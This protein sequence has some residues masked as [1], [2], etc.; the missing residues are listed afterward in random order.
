MNDEN[1]NPGTEIDADESTLDGAVDQVDQ[2]DDAQDDELDL[3]EESGDESTQD[4]SND[5]GSSE[6]D[7]KAAAALA[8]MSGGTDQ[9]DPFARFN[10]EKPA[11]KQPEAPDPKAQ[12]AAPADAGIDLD[13]MFANE[14]SRLLETFPDLDDEAAKKYVEGT[15]KQFAAVVGSIQKQAE[16]AVRELL[17]PIV[18]DLRHARESVK[19]ENTRKIDTE[20]D[21]LAEADGISALGSSKNLT[22]TTR[23]F[24]TLV[25]NNANSAVQGWS[26]ADKA[27]LTNAEFLKLGIPGAIS[28]MKARGIKVPEPKQNARSHARGS[29]NRPAGSLLASQ[30]KAASKPGG[31]SNNF[32]QQALEAMREVKNK[33]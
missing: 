33:K 1:N 14:T 8:E 31:R 16:R 5:D 26:Q 28:Q 2:G 27:K 20:M 9:S 3:G 18:P 7:A 25:W 21:T 23:L 17:G 12:A 13:A 6:D 4:E 32:R 29:S 15:K 11:D 10:P 22:A 30:A 24:R 19:A